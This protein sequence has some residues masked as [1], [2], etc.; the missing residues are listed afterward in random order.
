MRSNTYLFRFPDFS[1]RI[2]LGRTQIYSLIHD[3]LLMPP[4]RLAAQAVAWPSDEVDAYVSAKIRGASN[5]ELRALVARLM[6][7][8][9]TAGSD[10]TAEVSA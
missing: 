3:G 2:G 8:R 4:V 9:T 6:A 7:A 1:A 5:D 10:N